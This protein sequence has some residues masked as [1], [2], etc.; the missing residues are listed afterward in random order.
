MK[1]IFI[2]LLLLLVLPGVLAISLDIQKKSSGEVMIPQIN[3]P[4]IFNLSIKNLGES[5][6]FEFFNLVGFSMAPK[7]TVKIDRGET[8]DVSVMIYPR[9][10]FPVRGYYTFAYSIKGNT[11]TISPQLTVK[12][13]D[14]EDAFEVGVKEFDSESNKIIVYIH[15]KENFDFGKLNVEFSS[16]FFKTN[17]E[18]SLGP[19]QE[20]Q[21][22]VSLKEEDF[23]KLSAGFYTLSA[24]VV[25]SKTSAVV[26]GIIN[27]QE[28]SE[29]KSTTEDSG[30]LIDTKIIKKENQGNIDYSTQIK[31]KKNIISRLFTSF[32]PKPDTTERKNIFV[33]YT[34]EKLIKPGESFT[35]VVK[36]NWIFPLILAILIAVIIYLIS[37][38]SRNDL[39]VK[40]RIQFVHSKGGEFA[41]RVSLTLH[42]RRYI[43]KVKL[44]DRLPALV[45]LY[46]Q[47]GGQSPSSF[48][49]EKRRIEW[50]FQKLEAG[51]VRVASYLIYSKVGVLGKFALPTATATYQ[52]EGKFKDSYSNI[53]FFMAEPRISDSE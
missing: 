9:D 45:R 7:G 47:F 42:A 10:N 43:E 46:H 3:Q 34:W 38:Y 5:D 32:E 8:V 52:K 39:T 51:E 31:V 27:F 30:I 18:F 40:K 14:F 15:N 48:S 17:K 4:S 13:V 6:N 12:I 24:K 49:E 50:D 2:S 19:N 28:N 29:I 37:N 21:F 26:E 1:K 11:G 25:S 44:V 22:E 16:A 36:T 41:L 20:K 35:V 23:N 33:E 53:A